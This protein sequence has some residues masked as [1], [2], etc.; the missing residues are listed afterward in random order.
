MGTDVERIVEC[1]RFVHEVW[2][3]IPEVVIGVSL[4]ARQVSYASIAPL[5]ICASK[6]GISQS[7][8]LSLQR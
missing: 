6:Y 8:V 5:V 2:A 3:A 4:L 1:L 7:W